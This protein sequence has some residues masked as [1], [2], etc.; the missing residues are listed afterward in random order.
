MIIDRLVLSVSSPG[1]SLVNSANE[2][3]LFCGV[4]MSETGR[5]P[6]DLGRFFPVAR[7]Y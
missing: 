7:F 3:R 4:S 6:R 1:K 5:D 2:T